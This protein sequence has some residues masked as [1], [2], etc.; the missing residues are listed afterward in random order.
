M[1]FVCEYCS[2]NLPVEFPTNRQN[3]STIVAQ[4]GPFFN[5]FSPVVST[6]IRTRRY[7]DQ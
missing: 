1:E 4:T 3:Q 6:R 2:W 5:G 7:N